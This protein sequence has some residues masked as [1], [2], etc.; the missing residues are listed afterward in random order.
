MDES[1]IVGMGVGL[2]LCFV[3][4]AVWGTGFKSGVSSGNRRMASAL[5]VISRGVPDAHIVASMVLEE[6]EKDS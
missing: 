4:M 5:R 6:I 3:F 2:L 1:L